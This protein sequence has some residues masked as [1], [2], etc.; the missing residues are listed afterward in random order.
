MLLSKQTKQRQSEDSKD[1]V[2]HSRVPADH[3]ASC[4]WVAQA[5]AE[6]VTV[7]LDPA[8]CVDNQRWLDSAA[9]LLSATVVPVPVAQGTN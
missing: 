7:Y 2:Q 5:Q 6:Q 8:M 4:S 1:S 3:S 9:L